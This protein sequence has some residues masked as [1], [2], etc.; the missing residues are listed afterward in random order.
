M[1]NEQLAGMTDESVADLHF[2]FDD[3]VD[4][5]WFRRTL[6]EWATYESIPEVREEMVD[7][8]LDDA[9]DDEVEEDETKE[10]K[11]NDVAMNENITWAEAQRGIE[12][13]KAYF[14]QRGMDKA[15]QDAI[16]L[17]MELLMNKAGASN[18]QTHMSDFFNLSKPKHNREL[19]STA[20]KCLI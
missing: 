19:S 17:E 7:D 2:D 14:I 13:A 15:V 20:E 8:L 1:E 12:S 9:E 3:K 4:K 18:L 16:A 11:D 6:G 10:Y 5:E